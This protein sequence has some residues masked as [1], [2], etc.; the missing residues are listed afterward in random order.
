M[1][2]LFLLLSF[3]SAFLLFQV[4]PLIS[5]FILPWF[6]GSP[7]VWT[8]CM[9]FF[10]VVLF[11]GYAYA[12]AVV[13][14]APRV[15][16]WLHTGL[17]LLSLIFLPIAPGDFWKPS[18]LEEPSIRI[19]LLLLGTVGLPYF[20][21]SS[22]SPLTQ[23]WFCRRFQDRSPW[24]LY[25]LSNVGSLVALLTYPV[26]I[27]PYFDV[28]LQTWVWSFGFILFAVISILLAKRGSL[29]AE[30][31]AITAT[32]QID[33]SDH[34]PVP[35]W[36]RLL[37][38]LLPMMASVLL[39]ASTNHVCQDIAVIPFMWVIPL[40]L[41][42]LTFIISFEFE[43]YYVRPLFSLLAIGVIGTT[44]L[45]K[46]IANLPSWSWDP[47]P[48]YL[49]DLAWSF[50]AMFLGALLCHAEL[51]RL[52]PRRSGL[53]VFYLC[54][55]AGGAL[56]GLLVSQLAPRIF[57]TYL[58][59]PLALICG[60]VVAVVALGVSIWKTCAR[61]I[62]LLLCSAV[63][64]LGVFSVAFL[65]ES[66]LKVDH[67]LERTRNF[68]GAVNVDEDYDTGLESTY[69]TLTHGGI[70]HG[71]QNIADAHREEPVTYYGPTTGIGQSL[72]AL[73]EKQDAHVAIVGMGAGTVACYAR[74]GQRWRFY[75]INPEIPRLARKHFTY[76]A[77]AEKRGAKI[78]TI[79]GDARLMLDREEHQQ[80]DLLLLDAFSGDSIPV[81]LLTQEAFEIYR[82]HMK[83]NGIIVVHITNTYLALAPVVLKQAQIMKWKTARVITEEDGDHDATDYICMTQNQAFIQK[84][85]VDEPAHQE[86]VNVP[87]WTDK[88]YDLFRILMLK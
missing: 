82:R 5:K 60:F 46:V 74:P 8:T 33:K 18:G 48:N 68:Y 54:L 37:W 39:L 55:S 16:K 50:G 27:E 15:Q 3:I 87:L 4:Q 12:H 88:R 67:R 38:I 24:R 30:P 43:N 20:I 77:D 58:E 44:A 13:K 17:V 22:T 78:E 29:P 41:Y 51:A 9:L 57:V 21:L 66:T 36:Q 45:E 86:P 47:T 62:R 10:Q 70:I 7:A 35:W 42:L 26:L 72:A 85:M 84:V 81:H 71:M 65:A 49:Y 32:Q 28:V 69:R 83:P 63:A 11:V 80:F 40:S 19:L 76:L 75:E 59:W 6:G 79:L 61:T 2:V 23:V 1:H 53:T 73:S 25:A 64:G 14:L 52:K 31:T 34:I 56:G